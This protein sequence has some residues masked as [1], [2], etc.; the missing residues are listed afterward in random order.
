[1]KQVTQRLRDG[2]IEVLDVPAPTVGPGEVLV[3]VRAS[4]ISAGTERTKVVTGR[5]SLAGKAR[6]RPDQ[7]RQ[8]IEKAR[9]D[10]VRATIDAVRLR[11]DAP[12]PLGYSA[13]GVVLEVGDRVTGIAPGDR[14]ACAGADYAVHAE[15]VRVP[16]NLCVRV[17]DN[18]A[19]DH[20]AFA[21]IG[22]IALHGVRQTEAALGERVAVIGMGLVGQLAGQLLRA[23]GC[24]VVGVDL[25]SEM[26]DLARSSGASD[27]AFLRSDLDGLLPSAA[28]DCDAV[29]ITAAAPTS[30]PVELAARLA[31][32]RGRVVVIGDVRLDVPRT[33]F[34]EKEL[35]L[36]LSR[37]YGPGRYDREYEERGLD[38]PVGYVRW[39]ERRNLE[40]FVSIVG[41]GRIDLEPLI[42]GRI[43]LQDAA[44]AYDRLATGGIS[45]LGI[46]LTYEPYVA[47]RPRVV[48]AVS[49]A[50]GA[51]VGLIGAGSFAQRVLVPAMRSAGFDPVAV[52][53]AAGLSAHVVAERLGSARTA[54]VEE[55]LAAEDIDLAVIATRHSTHASLTLA[56]LEAGKHVFVEKPPALEIDDL[57][58]I[59]HLSR[60]T[61]LRVAVGF[62]R[63]YAPL[64]HR[65]REHVRESG[66]PIELLYRVNAGPL[67]PDH[68]LNDPDEGGGRL[69]GEGCHFVD[70]ACWVAG[71]IP[72]A[73]SASIDSRASVREAE[74]F[75]IA[76]TFDGGSLAT[77]LYTS[78]GAGRLGKEYVEAH[79]GGRSAVL[80]DFR[81][82]D[83]YADASR[84]QHLDAPAGKGH[85]QEFEALKEELSGA[86]EVEGPD[87]LATMSVTLAAVE[88][89]STGSSVVPRSIVG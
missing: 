70:F 44:A 24:V 67:A 69:L 50:V 37:S 68:W 25:S 61:G 75:S 23:A 6:A 73:V 17:P 57:V 49:R 29:L 52:A 45:P 1:V 38:Y 77:I 14:V 39:T 81:R 32:D 48:P 66:A 59:A 5:K 51:R 43:P 85:A 15:L 86:R 65:F 20:A 72:R 19:L 46:V 79:A 18:V 8:V 22:A 78:G 74:S 62:N 34:Y 64:A 36:R 12:S 28:A 53:S 27:H 13:A 89:A 58:R 33:A 11:L 60:T 71:G 80:D 56:A 88:S 21:T 4:V 76:L 82:V 84:R 3:D 40:A 7:V 26:L 42:T 35:E 2:R 83:A 55:L 41:S 31:R 30:D 10:G 9:R 87:P 63:R 47:E 54:T 16:V